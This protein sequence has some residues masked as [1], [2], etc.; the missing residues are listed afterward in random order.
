MVTMCKREEELL[1][2]LEI[3]PELK[4][5]FEKYVGTSGE[6]VTKTAEERFIMDIIDSNTDDL[7]DIT[8]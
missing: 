8:D 5:G 3:S 7:K 4:A 6:M 2:T 1:K